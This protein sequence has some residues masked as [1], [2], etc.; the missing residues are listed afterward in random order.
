MKIEVFKKNESTIIIQCE[1]RIAKE[2]SNFFSVYAPNYRFAPKYKSGCWDGKI[3]FFSYST[4][5]LPI[6]LLEKVISF[7]KLGKYDIDIKFERF[8]TI[9]KSEF[10][11]FIKYLN[12]PFEPRDYQ[13]EA[14]YQACCKKHLNIHASTAAG[15]SLIIYIIFKF[16]EIQGLKTLL[17]VPNVNLVNQMYSDFETYNMKDIDSK[18]RQIYAG[19]I[20][21][22]DNPC[23]ISTWQSIMSFNKKNSKDSILSLYDCIIIDESHLAKGTELASIAKLAE[24][25]QYRFG[26]SGTYP[27]NQTADWYSIV[28]SLGPIQTFAT[29]KSLQENNHIAKIKIFPVIFQY[30]VDFKKKVYKEGN[31]DYNK[32]NDLIYNNESRSKMILKMVQQTKKN[33]LVLFTKKEKHG[34]PLKELFE[35]ELKGKTLL[36]IDGDVDPKI[37]DNIRSIM[38]ERND[39]VL[40]ATYATLSTGWSVKN[41]HSIF[42]V[43]SYK[44]KVKVLQSIGRMLRLHK[45]K[46]ITK[47][48]DIVDDCA[49]ID[50][51]NNI[52]FI[53]YSF[54]HY[55]ERMKFYEEQNWEIKSVKVK[56]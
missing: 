3:R 4:H 36:Y 48:F 23:T 5:E 34:Y 25:A 15:K 22:F 49:F 45:D 56:L 53:N 12:L 54:R 10:L 30:P 13:I 46:E 27:D 43:S 14:A 9:D 1:D 16:L 17:V 38:E 42:F 20:K 44:S 32:E 19:Q 40:L 8:N 21:V 37:R 33:C 47:L 7:A 31:Q 52:K 39:V 2:L 55:K 28:G 35:K 50:K 24:N 51:L 11:R 41:L 26:L 29:Y 6:G 18:I